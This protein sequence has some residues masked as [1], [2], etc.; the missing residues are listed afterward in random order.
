MKNVAN[1]SRETLK[2]WKENQ[3]YWIWGI[4]YYNKADKR[5]LPPK[6]NENW[7]NTINFANPKSIGFFLITMAFFSFIIMMILKNDD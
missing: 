2:E 5:I 7:G 6:Q 1:P 4:F 3:K